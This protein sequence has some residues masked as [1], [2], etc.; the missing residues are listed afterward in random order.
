MVRR[1]R[2]G[3]ALLPTLGLILLSNGGQSP[4]FAQNTLEEVTSLNFRGN[5][6]FPDEVL[7]NA[8]I[9]RET[10]CRS[11][12][13]L[14]FCW[15]GASFSE[16]PYFLHARE[17]RRDQARIRLFYYQRGYRETVVDTLVNR[18]SRREVEITFEIQEGEPVRVVGLGFTGME[19]FPDSSVVEDLPVRLGAPLNALSLEAARDSLSTRLRG[20]GFAHAEVL[21]NYSIPRDSPLEASVTFDL[22]PGQEAYLGPLSVVGNITVPEVVVRRMLPFREGD[23]FSQEE[24]LAGQRNLDN[25][26]I[27]RRANVI[28][29]LTHVPDSIVPLLIQ[30]SEGDVHRVR[31]GSGLSTADCVNTEARWVSRNFFGGARRLQVTGRVSKLLAPFLEQT[32]CQDAGTGEYGELNWLLSADFTQPWLFSPRNSLSASVFGERQSLPDIFVRQALGLNLAVSHTLMVATPVTFSVRPEISRLDAAEIFFCSNYLICTPEDIGILQG[33]NWLAPL[34]LRFAQDRRN[35]ALSPTRGHSVLLDLEVA[36]G[37]TGSDYRYTRVLTEASWYTQARSRLVLAARLRGG[38]LNPG[39]F[40]GL[41]T[42]GGSENVVPPE[43]RLYAGGSNSVRGFAQNRLGPRVLYLPQV[44]RVLRGT[45]DGGPPPCTPQE[46]MSLS[47]DANPL[48]DAAF[49]TRPTGGTAMVEGSV[50]LRFPVLGQVWE[51]AT[52]LDFGQVWEE[53][54]GVD[55][56]D[57]EFTPGLGIRYFSPIGPIRVDLAYRFA[58]GDRLQVVTSQIRE[59][60]EGRDEEGDKLDGLDYVLSDDLA[61]LS[62]KVLWGE[63][64]PWSIRRLQLHLSIGQAF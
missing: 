10:E 22:Y 32:V 12:I 8:I 26:D 39:G 15:S 2:L 54:L 29:D 35:Q 56:T 14:P 7:A 51:G 33:S 62:P 4:L 58:P 19:R 57:M 34:G 49:A 60:V 11:F 52:F 3:P 53:D 45:P 38:W 64:G 44:E 21:L 46:V 50:E 59:F 41:S 36:S 24:L 18:P 16:D 13:L 61:L 9:T 17:F 30:V 37:L 28:P 5:R 23:S 63:V 1:K 47:C 31:A 55:L 6:Q 27:F 43:K 25:L 42:P 48:S 40:E 20:R